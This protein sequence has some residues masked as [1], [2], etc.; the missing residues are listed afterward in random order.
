MWET[1]MA[2]SREAPHPHIAQMPEVV[3]TVASALPGTS[4]LSRCSEE[5]T[6]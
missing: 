1:E 2:T 6:D 5:I 3:M 4:N